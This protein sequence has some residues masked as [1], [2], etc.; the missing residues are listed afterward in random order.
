MMKDVQIVFD[1]DPCNTLV[2]DAGAF[3]KLSKW[4][5][6]LSNCPSAVESNAFRTRLKLKFI[7][8]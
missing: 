2:H 7:I 6:L 3:K 1:R 4:R 8:I 5:N